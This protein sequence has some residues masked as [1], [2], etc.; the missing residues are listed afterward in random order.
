MQDSR[1]ILN[2]LTSRKFLVALGSLI[3]ATLLCWNHMIAD[4]VYSVVMVATVGAYLTA[5]VI[6][7]NIPKTQ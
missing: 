2:N 7:K 1:S 6:Q 3:S 5:N 4:G